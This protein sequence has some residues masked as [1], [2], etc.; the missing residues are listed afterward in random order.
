MQSTPLF[1]HP[2]FPIL[3]GSKTCKIYNIKMRYTVP[4]KQKTDIVFYETDTDAMSDVNPLLKQGFPSSGTS[5]SQ[6]SGQSPA[7][8]MP[9]MAFLSSSYSPLGSISHCNSAILCLWLI[10][11]K[12]TENV[13]NP[14]AFLRNYV[15][16]AGWERGLV[17]L[18]DG[19]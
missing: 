7:R 13:P 11:V 17:K 16:R 10:D 8:R 5:T 6:F 2:K 9:A 14:V 12:M 19:E 1:S 18:Y 4:L 3:T 15:S